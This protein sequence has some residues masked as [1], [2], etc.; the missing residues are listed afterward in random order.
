M[1]NFNNL[2]LIVRD[3]PAA[4]A[5]FRDVVGLKVRVGE[6][7]FAELESGAA[8]IMLS[9]DAMVPTEPARGVILHFQVEDVAAALAHARGLGATVLLETTH[10]DWGTESAM[11]AGPEGIIVDFFRPVTGPVQ[12]G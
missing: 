5:F 7:R 11:I 10:T 12:P 9:P 1:P 6:E 3:V 8:T 2:D 4:T